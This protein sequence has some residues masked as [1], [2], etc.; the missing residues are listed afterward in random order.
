MFIAED[1]FRQGCAASPKFA[2]GDQGRPGATELSQAI[3]RKS[4]WSAHNGNCVEVAEL[5][6]RLIGV[7]DTKDAGRGPVLLFADTAWRSFVA[8]VKYGR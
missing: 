5:G 1:G 6:D 8:N 4:S 7:R 3:W 2:A